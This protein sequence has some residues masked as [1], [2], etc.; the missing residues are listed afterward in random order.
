M[1]T[2][3]HKLHHKLHTLI[4]VHVIV[5]PSLQPQLL[6]PQARLQWKRCADVP[7]GMYSAQAVVMGEKVYVGGG[8]NVDKYRIFQY[9]TTREEW[10]H[11]PHTVCY[12]AMAQFTGNLIT[13]GGGIPDSATSKVY[14]FKEESQEWEEF[15]KPMPT[16]RSLLSVTTTQS[17]IIA[18]GGTTDIRDGKFVL[19]TTVEVYSSETS[20][21]YTA[22]PLPAPYYWMSSVTIADTCYLLGGTDANGNHVPTVLYASLTSLIQKATSPTHQS[23][24]STSVWKTLPDTPLKLSTAASLSGNL[25]AMGGHDTKTTFPAINI[26][27]SL[28]NSWVR[29]MTGDL[30]QPRK[31][32]TAVQLSSNTMIVIGG[33]DNQNSITKT[34][35]I[36]TVTV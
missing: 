16:A 11:F 20:Q 13:V 35:F 2:T 36:G 31:W 27:L 28:S 22:D 30:P 6:H 34:V 17:T 10:S 29:I 15:I 26:F 3:H 9:T 18:I 32:C 23:G 7:V 4:P 1:S 25:L 21:W 14:R 19:C 12:F 33:A 8:R 24:R 5:V